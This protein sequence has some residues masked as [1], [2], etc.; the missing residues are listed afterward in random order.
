MLHAEEMCGFGKSLQSGVIKHTN[1]T[2]GAPAYSGGEMVML[3][4]KTMVING[5]SGRYGPRSERELDAAA[6]AFRQS[7]YHVW[8]MGYDNEAGYP[9]PFGVMPRWVV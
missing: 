3:D 8:C 9:L 5:Q 4:E 7:G 1:L 6:K 2:G